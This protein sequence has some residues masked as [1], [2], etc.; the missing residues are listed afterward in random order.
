MICIFS[1]LIDNSTTDIIRWLHHLG[2]KDV[3]R[4][5]ANDTVSNNSLH[6]DIDTDGFYF[7]WQDQSFH[8]SEIEAVW[9]RKGVNW[10]GDQ[11]Y[12]IEP[13]APSVF[14]A[15]V[16]GKIKNE[17][18]KLSEYLHYVI[19][20]TVPVLGSPAKSDLNKLVVLREAAA[21]GLLTPEFHIANYREGLKQ[22]LD[23]GTEWITKSLSDGIYL[24]DKAQSGKG[25]F[26]Y[27][28]AVDCGE[29]AA[30]PEKLS[31]S[32][33]QKCISKKYELRIFFLIDKCYAMAIFSQKDKQTQ[34]DY[35]KYNNSRP[36][37]FVPF[38]LPDHIDRKI[39]SL[40]TKLE[41]NTGSADMIVDEEGQYY[42]LEINPVGQFGMVS[43]PCNYFLEKEVASYLTRQK[44]QDVRQ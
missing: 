7:Q 26:T 32:F 20:T 9:Y 23:Q 37:R 16:N 1:S 15:H 41:L 12:K 13:E 14:A 10:L 8:L 22:V 38:R 25:Y 6:F 39:K 18:R 4:I 11:F 42:F 27:T 30:L 44:K 31:P 5:N 28:E 17:E 34:V 3:I 19:Q 21:V 29:I 40:F 36:N 33:L 24:F 35:R 43:L 2:R